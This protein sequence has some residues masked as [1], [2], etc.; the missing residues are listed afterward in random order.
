[1]AFFVIMLYLVLVYSALLG[2]NVVEAESYTFMCD[3]DSFS[4][5]PMC[6]LSL[7]FY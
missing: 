3:I 1:M 7:L 6:A 5:F 2:A 4:L